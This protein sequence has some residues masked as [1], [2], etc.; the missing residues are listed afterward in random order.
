MNYQQQYQ[1]IIG[2]VYIQR[3]YVREEHLSTGADLDYLQCLHA[4]TQNINQ[5]N[6]ITALRFSIFS[7]F[8]LFFT[9]SYSSFYFFHNIF[10]Y[11]YLDVYPLCAKKIQYQTFILKSRKMFQ[12][13]AESKAR[14]F[15]HLI[16][17]YPRFS[18]GSTYLA[19]GR[20]DIPVYCKNSSKRIKPF[21][22]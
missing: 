2:I 3:N 22:K 20:C 16:A 18:V 9:F 14:F 21:R 15:R 5:K 11:F 19:V 6:T 4:D 17:R 7:M 10:N 13:S 8:T 1:K 12:I